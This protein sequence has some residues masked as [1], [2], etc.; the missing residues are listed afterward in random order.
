LSVAYNF[1]RNFFL[2]LCFCKL[3]DSN[4]LNK[5]SFERWLLCLN[6]AFQS[7]IEM[8]P[9]FI[10]EEKLELCEREKLHLSKALPSGIFWIIRQSLVKH[11]LSSSLFDVLKT[12]F[13][14]ATY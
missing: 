11:I 2:S 10:V 5:G 4:A 13:S 9:S 6:C 1:E 14:L 8:P 3:F 12:I 7:K